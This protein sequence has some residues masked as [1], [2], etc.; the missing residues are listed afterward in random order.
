VPAPIR[1]RIAQRIKASFSAVYFPTYLRNVRRK[2]KEMVKSWVSEIDLAVV[3]A[4]NEGK[5]VIHTCSLK[6]T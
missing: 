1:K 3:L 6:S 2:E 5:R 4:Q